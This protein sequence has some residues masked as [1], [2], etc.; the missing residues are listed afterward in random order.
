MGR[1]FSTYER[2]EEQ[3]ILVG[4]PEEKIPLERLRNIWKCVLD[5]I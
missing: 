4:K 1:A 2:E 5:R 3:T